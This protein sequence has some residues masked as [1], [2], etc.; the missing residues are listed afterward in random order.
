MEKEK[1]VLDS[2][3]FKV[4]SLNHNLRFNMEQFS[5][6]GQNFGLWFV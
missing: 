1:S 5:R 6:E 3:K 4:L 2:Y